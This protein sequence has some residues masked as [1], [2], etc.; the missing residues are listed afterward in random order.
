MK[1]IALLSILLSM[2]FTACGGQAQPTEQSF[3]PI[4]DVRSSPTPEP[5]LTPAEQAAVERLASI[6]NLPPEKIGVVSTE[7]VEWPDGC[8]GIERPGMMCTQAIVPGYRILLE[9]EGEQFEFRTNE[10]GSQVAQAGSAAP[11]GLMEEAIMAQLAANLGLDI[12]K[13]SLVGSSE[14]EF[15]D[16][17]LGVAFM[18]E[19]CAQVVTPG[20]IIVLEANG[21]QF[22]YHLSADG[23]RV[24]P[25]TLALTWTR[26][27]GIAGFCDR[28]TVFLS[29]E[30]YGSNCRAQGSDAEMKILADL[31]STSEREK[32]FSWVQE[33]G[34][35]DI[36]VSDP[37][38]AA[39]RMIVT[40]EFQGNGSDQPSEIE[41]QVLL[42]FAQ[43]LYQKLNS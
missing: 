12:D 16:S 18:D 37:V 24:Q 19:A 38:A 10:S 20:K 31:L 15:P 6:L 9:A 1:R 11:I 36:E 40:L 33:F 7:A 41:K 26:E 17:C 13:I 5:E 30:V 4:D 29:G 32:F 27:G 14:V 22:E 42:E 25:A 43:S 34:Q 39:D 2:F 23:T 3:I 8:L 21:L 28:L 35:A